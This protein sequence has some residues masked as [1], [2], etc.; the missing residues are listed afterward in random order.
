MCASVAAGHRDRTYSEEEC[1]R[2]VFPD[3]RPIMNDPLYALQRIFHLPAFRGV[4]LPVITTALKGE[5]VFAI[6]PTGAG[7]S[8]C[9][10]V[11]RSCV[12][13]VCCTATSV[14]VVYVVLSM[15]ATRC[16]GVPP[17]DPC[18]LGTVRLNL[19]VPSWLHA[20]LSHALLPCV[21]LRRRSA[22]C[23]RTARRWSC[24]R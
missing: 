3:G 7:K 8:L 6:M 23:L 12:C 1:R 24:P 22:L 18:C 11:C 20:A 10:Q 4:Q 5:D 21:P 2:T 19:P 14:V 15:D 16:S 13:V 9:Y 17:S